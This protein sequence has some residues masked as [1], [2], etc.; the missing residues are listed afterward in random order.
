MPRNPMTERLLN[1]MS[2]GFVAVALGLPFACAP[3][4]QPERPTV[5]L[6]ASSCTSVR[7]N[8][9]AGR[10]T[11]GVEFEISGSSQAVALQVA[12]RLRS[13]ICSDPE[14]FAWVQEPDGSVVPLA[15]TN[16]SWVH[17]FDPET[18][19]IPMISYR[20]PKPV[21]VSGA[22]ENLWRVSIAVALPVERQPPEVVVVGLHTDAIRKE[23]EAY[24]GRPEVQIEPSAF[25]ATPK[26]LVLPAP[27]RPES[28]ELGAEFHHN[29]E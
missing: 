20:V 19:F 9:K 7:P 10:W 12:S 27:S 18:E 14:K 29:A 16:S 11:M 28:T 1:R 15:G 17:Q 6:S 8:W 25:T 26:T 24:T 23:L 3:I 22:G 4:Q 5:H 2:I 13:V 21:K